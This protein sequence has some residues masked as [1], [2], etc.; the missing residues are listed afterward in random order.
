MKLR[1]LL[2]ISMFICS[3]FQSNTNGQAR[4]QRSGRSRFDPQNDFIVTNKVNLGLKYNFFVPGDMPRLSVIVALPRTLPDRQKILSTKFSIRP[5]RMINENGNRYAEY[6]FINPDK[7]IEIE[8]SM[9]IELFRY[10]LFTAQNKRIRSRSKGPGFSDFL[11][12][13]KYLEIDNPEIR[14]I[15]ESI[16]EGTQLETVRNIY[17]YVI[18]NMEYT[19]IGRRDL[20]AAKAL[21]QG[22]GDCTEYSDLF[23]ALCRAR[24]IHARSCV[25]Y[26]VQ[27]DVSQSRHNWAEVYLDDYGWVPFDL[28]WGNRKDPFFREQAF[29]RLSPVYIYLSYLRN[30][31]VLHNYQ[32]I[33]YNYSGDKVRLTE[34]IEFTFDD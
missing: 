4:P 22:K 9:K 1:E 34:S 29:S 20:G 18:D 14:K 13:E 11:Q 32:F 26:T 19:S 5:T 27:H 23:V 8:I 33:C 2:I 7:K 15:A 28:I 21:R 25:G 10:D 24:G 3:I 12:K 6:V 16:E 31:E 17:N 30:D